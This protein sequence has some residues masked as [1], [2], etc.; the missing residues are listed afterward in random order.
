MKPFQIS[1]FLARNIIN[2]LKGAY[3]G[4]VAGGMA[5]GYG[6][7]GHKKHHK[8]HKHGK[9]SSSSSSSSSSDDEYV[10]L[11]YVVV[12]RYI[13]VVFIMVRSSIILITQYSNFDNHVSYC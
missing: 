5:M 10:S 12:C 13:F 2:Y 3:P 6:V 8:H 1:S 9:H 4:A 7:H 11:V